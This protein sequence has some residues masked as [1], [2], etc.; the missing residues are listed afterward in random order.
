MT[1]TTPEAPVFDRASGEVDIWPILAAG[2]ASLAKEI[3]KGDHDDYLSFLAHCDR[4][5]HDG[6]R[7]QVQEAV[8]K[9]K[10]L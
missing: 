7:P 3:S 4:S 9:R 8:A 5:Q 10:G 1:K 6:G 2:A